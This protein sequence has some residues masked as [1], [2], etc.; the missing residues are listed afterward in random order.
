MASLFLTGPILLILGCKDEDE[1]PTT[2]NL[3]L[4]ITGL[5]DLGDN[6][7]YE[8]WAV[9]DGHPISTGTFE[10]VSDVDDSAPY[11]VTDASGRPFP[12]EDFLMNAPSHLSFPTDLAGKT[13]VISVE[14][15]PDNSTAPFLLK[16]LVGHIPT[17]AT[18]HKLYNMTNNA[19]A[20]NPTG[21]INR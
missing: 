15:S 18:D 19:I 9:V 6:F 1:T 7:A 2:K 12:G 4:N 14:P 5:E 10:N 8:G 17:D 13:V 16:P 21:V 11:S 3:T 20:T